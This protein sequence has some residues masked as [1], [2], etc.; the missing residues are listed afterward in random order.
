S[1]LDAILCDPIFYACQVV[2]EYAD[3]PIQIDVS[4]LGIGEPFTSL[5]HIPSPPA[6]IPQYSLASKMNL[7]ERTANVIIN[8]ILLPAL[9]HLIFKPIYAVTNAS[10]LGL[11]T[12]PRYEVRR[13]SF[14]IANGDFA[15]DYPQPLTPSSKLVG[16]ILAKPA[17][18]LPTD[19]ERFITSNPKGAIVVS[20]GTVVTA[21]KHIV[22]MQI[23]F[24]AFRRLPYN[25]IWKYDEELPDEV[26]SRNLKLVQWLPQNDLLGHPQ[27]KAFVTHCGYN[28]I[29]E[30]GYHG[31]PMVGIPIAGDQIAHA[32][33]I[34][35]RTIGVILN[36]RTLASDD[37][38][39]AVMKVTSDQDILGNASKVSKI[40]K[41]R[42]NG[43]KP[44]EEAGDWVEYALNCNGGDYL[45]TE[46]YN[47]KW[48]EFY[49]LD[50]F[51]VMIAICYLI[52][53]VLRL[54]WNGMVMLCSDNK[55]AKV[56]AS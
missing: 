43:R 10:K 30:A 31:V 56:K 40:I 44:V 12:I 7:I 21:L 11:K 9:N 41:N 23:F 47:L 33:K 3:I 14:L 37:L 36:I 54:L 4:P 49:L 32:N 45:R 55:K 2:A 50:V 48:Y 53:K 17:Q 13:A 52:V 25:V 22:D 46:E 8:L 18:S 28:G 1:F 19:L 6:Y 39:N 26:A 20:F 27:V 24:Y 51:A 35:A 42:P 29:L 15:I 16:P 34:T 5:H 38:Y